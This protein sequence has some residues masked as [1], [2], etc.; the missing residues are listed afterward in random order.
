MPPGEATTYVRPNGEIFEIGLSNCEFR[1]TI[2]DFGFEMQD[3]SDFKIFSVPCPVKYVD[4]PGESDRA[5]DR[6]NS[7]YETEIIF[8]I[9]KDLVSYREGV[10]RTSRIHVEESEIG[11]TEIS[12]PRSEISN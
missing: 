10:H 11:P 1:F 8:L 2:S 6:E 5:A 9:R 3:S 4:P 12:D 7:Q